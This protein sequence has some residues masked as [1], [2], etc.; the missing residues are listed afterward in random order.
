MTLLPAH[1]RPYALA[2]KHVRIVN[3]IAALWHRPEECRGY[4]DELLIDRRGERKGFPA[5]VLQDLVGLR[6]LHEELFPTI[7]M[8]Q[9]IPGD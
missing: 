1:R 6:R 3:M 8:M 5:D 7:A 9:T 4:L 2:R